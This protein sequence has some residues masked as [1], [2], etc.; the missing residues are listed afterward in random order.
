MSRLLAAW[1]TLTT[2][3]DLFLVIWQHVNSPAVRRT[4]LA[5]A[6]NTAET[7]YDAFETALKQDD[8]ADA[9]AKVVKV[10]GD[11]W[12]DQASEKGRKT[13]AGLLLGAM[14][15]IDDA[16]LTI[17]PRTLLARST[18]APPPGWA[19]AA[20]DKR[21]I[22]G[23]Y[24]AT[25]ERGLVPR[26]PFARNTRGPLETS[27]FS[28]ADQFV[29]CAV[30]PLAIEEDGRR[31]EVAVTVV[32]Q[33]VA[34]G[35][36]PRLGRSGSEAITLAPLAE[37][38][39]D[40]VARVREDDGT[41]YIDVEQG[42]GFAPHDIFAGMLSDL[43][44][45]DVL[46]LPELVVAPADV[47][48]MRDSLATSSGDRPRLIVCG[49]G[50]EANGS[51]PPWNM[52]YIVNGA[53]APLWS[54]R[55]LVAY[56]MLETTFANLEIKDIGK[57]KQ[58][59]EQI[60]WSNA[61]T[62]GDV[63]GLGRCLVLICQ[64]LMMAG[65]EPLIRAYEPDYLFL[66]ILDSGTNF[67]RWPY[68]RLV[69][70]SAAGPTRFVAVSSLTMQ[71]WR[72]KSYPGEQIGVAVG[73]RNIAAGDAG[74]DGERMAQEIVCESA[75]RRHGSIRWRSGAWETVPEPKPK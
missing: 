24:A 33:G 58:L 28:L 70:L 67:F 51:E 22:A 18:L 23:L 53:G 38:T 8:G 45:T 6:Y 73:P 49:S 4:H 62:I 34:R 10:L 66:P 41:F 2:P 54:H 7:V 57:A 29:A 1:G 30:V 21:T 26:G 63:E 65:I 16:F 42:A 64:D 52:S 55:K 71:H 74:A 61:I 20:R 13:R 56:D 19:I 75:T 48:A 59:M 31:I 44:D 14:R 35:V 9:V 69:D 60:S 40:L 72:K 11:Y 47:E 17:H 46:L 68:K 5:G 12:S 39:G 27:N 25:N 3:A 36:P 32:G 50:G 43:G 15:A 37:A